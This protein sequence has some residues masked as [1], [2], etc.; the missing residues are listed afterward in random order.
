MPRLIAT[1]SFPYANRS[2]KAGEPFEASDTDAK[3][4]T[5]VGK[6]RRT[7][8]VPEQSESSEPPKR[9]R[10]RPPKYQRMDMRAED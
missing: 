5:G 4:L 9:R 3:I 7:E 1:Q 8:S 2:L 10:G 6:A